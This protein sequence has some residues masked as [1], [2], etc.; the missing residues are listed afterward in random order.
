LARLREGHL[1]KAQQGNWNEVEF[2]EG[3]T[4]RQILL[5][6]AELQERFGTAVLFI[7]HDSGVVSEIANRI[8]VVNRGQMVEIGS[9]DEVL[10]NPK[11]E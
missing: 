4:Q 1:I 5:L 8:V 10:S 9:R 11:A 7:T 6:I 2:K 3:A